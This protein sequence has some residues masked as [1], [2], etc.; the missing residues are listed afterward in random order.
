MKKSIKTLKAK[1]DKVFSEWVR[2]SNADE[3]GICTCVT[4]GKRLPW[5]EIHNGHFISRRCLPVRFNEKNCNCQCTYCNT[6]SN[7]E[8]QKYFLWMENEY[9]REE[10]DKLIAL[11]ETMVK[12]TPSWYEE[13]IEDYSERVKLLNR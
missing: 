2:L 10:V 3:F 8:P 12:L 4:C 1:L 9:G 13:M 7:G 11:S 5:R 6:F